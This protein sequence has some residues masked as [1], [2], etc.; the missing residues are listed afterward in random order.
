M[1][2]RRCPVGQDDVAE[3]R[4]HG[5]ST[6]THRG[7]RGA[8]THWNRTAATGSSVVRRGGRAPR[9]EDDGSAPAV[10][11]IEEGIKRYLY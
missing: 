11:G 6:E 8:A 1:V 10:V 5:C 4:R 3:R 7:W 9:V 2:R